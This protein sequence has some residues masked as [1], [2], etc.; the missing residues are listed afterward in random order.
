MTR[1]RTR[2]G[3]EYAYTPDGDELPHFMPHN[4]PPAGLMPPV[5]DAGIAELD[6]LRTRISVAEHELIPLTTG[7]GHSDGWESAAAEAREADAHANAVA[8]REGKRITNPAAHLDAL[9]KRRD[10]LEA[11]VASL[12]G[13]RRMVTIELLNTREEEK[14]N[15]TYAEAIGDARAALAEATAGVVSKAE[16]LAIALA[17]A[18]WVQDNLPWDPTTSLHLGDVWPAAHTTLGPTGNIGEPVPLADI[19]AAINTL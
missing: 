15:T 3:R 14:S 9:R 18:E 11:E 10:Q 6:D 12:K 8:A 5:L 4:R 16:A 7:F 13:A 17:R 19:L 1:A 2:L